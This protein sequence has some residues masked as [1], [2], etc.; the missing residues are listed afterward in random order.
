VVED[1]GA[2]AHSAEKQFDRNARRETFLSPTATQQAVN[3]KFRGRS[4]KELAN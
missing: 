4:L 3:P 2:T 1:R